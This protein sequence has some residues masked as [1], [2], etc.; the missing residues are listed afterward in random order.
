MD[1]VR[2]LYD[3]WPIV[4]RPYSPAALH[5][6]ALL[7]YLPPQVEA[8]VALPAPLSGALEHA[9]AHTHPTSNTGYAHLKWEQRATTDP[10]R[11]RLDPDG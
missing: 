6:R 3:G 5:L 4:R 1:K 2:I 7:A 11:I 9:R 8:I 10:D